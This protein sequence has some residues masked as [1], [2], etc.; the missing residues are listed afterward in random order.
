MALLFVLTYL[1]A[2]EAASAV[3]LLLYQLLW[4]VPN[5]LITGLV[6]KN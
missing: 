3:N 4:Q 5:L 1:D 6:G 2:V